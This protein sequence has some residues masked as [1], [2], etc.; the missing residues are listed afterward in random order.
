M[1]TNERLHSEAMNVSDLRTHLFAIA[2][3]AVAL[4]VTSTKA[5]AQEP[6]GPTDPGVRCAAKVG[7]GQYEFFLPGERATDVNGNKWVCGPDGQW[8]RDYSAIVKGGTTG[9]IKQTASYLIANART[10]LIR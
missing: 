7:P 5:S 2:L 4:F 3:A 6:V 8:F 9:G 10:A 1:R